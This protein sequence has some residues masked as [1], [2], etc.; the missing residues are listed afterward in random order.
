[1]TGYLSGIGLAETDDADASVGL[2][3]AQD[4]EPTCDRTYGDVPHFA[5]VAPI[6]YGNK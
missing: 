5:V 4:M 3:E 6:V 1:M 2:C